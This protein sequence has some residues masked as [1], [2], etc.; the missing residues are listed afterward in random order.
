MSS[1]NPVDVLKGKIGTSSGGIGV[2]KALLMFQF[3]ISALL[4]FLTIVVFQQTQYL[5]KTD[6]GIDIKNTLVVKGSNLENKD[7]LVIAFKDELITYPEFSTVTS[8]NCLPANGDFLDNIWSD[9][10]SDKDKKLFTVVFTDYNYIPGLEVKLIAGRN[11]S[12]DFPSDKNAVIISESGIKQLGFNDAEEALKFKTNRE[13]GP[14]D[15]DMPIIGVVKDI[16]MGN[17]QKQ[18][19]PVIIYLKPNQKRFFAIK[20]KQELN[21]NT[22]ATIKSVWKKHF[23]VE[24]FRNFVLDE[25]YNKLYTNEI[26]NSKVLAL[27]SVLAIFVSI[28]GLWGLAYFS[29]KQRI[30][31]IGIRKVL[32]FKVID[33]VELINVDFLKLVGISCCIAIPLAWYLSIKWLEN[34]A[35]RIELQGWYFISPI[36]AVALITTITISFY[37]IKAA[38]SNPVEALRNE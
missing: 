20:S 23:G 8:A 12:K 9:K 4:I 6:L 17:L 10:Q 35:N 3:F 7:S 30:K 16:K 1:F 32:G 2:R 24:L 19:F 11:F 31:E 34:Y 13:Y 29:I 38:I 21:Q 22:V 14:K 37:T 36:L 28:I 26:R 5:L 15:R 33:I 25:S 27:F 18:S